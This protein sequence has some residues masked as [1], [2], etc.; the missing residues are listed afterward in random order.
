MKTSLSKLLK[1]S[2]QDQKEIIKKAIFF[3]GFRG[4]GI[5]G[6]YLFTLY[7][8]NNYGADLNG[9]VVLSFSIFMFATIIG[10]LGID[11]NLIKFY[12]T[13]GN[14]EEDPG[15]FY[16]VLLKSLFFS[17]LLVF[18]LY[19]ARDFLVIDLF[20]KPQLSPYYFW[21]IVAI[22]GWVITMLCAGA[23]RA[24]GFNNW[25]AFFNNTGRFS[26]AFI[27]VCLLGWIEMKPINILIAHFFGIYLLTM[28]ALIVIVKKFK[29]I[30]FRSTTNTWAFLKESF[31]MMLSSTIMI[32]LGW[33]D[34]F[35]LGVYETDES[36]GIYNVALKLALVTSFSIEAI[37]S[38]LA[39]KI[40]NAYVNNLKE[41]F[42]GL[43]K[44]ST[45]LNF[46]L[47]VLIVMVLLVFNQWFLG[48]FGEEFKAGSMALIILCA[49]H[50]INSAVGSVGI[51]M[52]MTGKQK[53]Y[54]YIAIISLGIN[55]LLNFILIPRYGINGA[56]IATAISLSVWNVSGCVYL[57]RKENIRTYL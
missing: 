18:I 23:L 17:S 16:R 54:Q 12:S 22:P 56:A 19:L 32:F 31:P 14:W 10:R 41:K 6:G 46:S 26:F 44:F 7:I 5:L 57:K 25:F 55:L 33:M 29:K 40:A 53:Q 39:P 38:S 27:F 45:R 36:I 8:T 30:S 51:I 21:A 20:K 34:T 11:V 24:R 2:D 48:M 42:L 50:L 28:I 47:T 13:E 43:I 37:N 9:L 35:I 52:Q 3:M 4:V 1:K 49:I 15:V